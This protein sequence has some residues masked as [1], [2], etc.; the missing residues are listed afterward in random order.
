MKRLLTI[1][2]ILA[3]TS[4]V[5]AQVTIQKDSTTVKIPI[6]LVQDSDLKSPVTGV[7]ISAGDLKFIKNGGTETNAGGTWTESTNADGLYFYT[8]AAGET[9]TVGS[10]VLKYKKAGTALTFLAS[11]V[12]PDPLNVAAPGSPVAGSAY[13][14]LKALTDP[15]GTVVAATGT[16]IDLAST[17]SALN[18]FL[19]TTNPTAILLVE[20]TGA[21]QWR[22]CQNYVGSNR[23]CTVTTW[24]TNPDTSTKYVKTPAINTSSGGGSISDS[25]IANAVWGAT[26]STYTTS[27][28]FG[29]GVASVQGNVTGTVNALAT[30]AKSDV[31][32]EV[33]S[34]LT[35]YAPATQSN[36]NTQFSDIKGTSFNT[37]TDSLRNIRTGMNVNVTIA[38][39]AID[40]AKIT[41]AA[42]NKIADHM[43]RRNNAN[44]ES[45]SNGDSLSFRSGYGAVAKQTNSISQSAGVLTIYKNDGTT[46]LGTQNATGSPGATPITG[47]STN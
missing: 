26:R 40:A 11:T 39:S 8:P 4:S 30:Q 43:W 7:T 36:V 47:L 42:A 24:S 5:S 31:N 1:P 15:D 3:F 13:A 41:A 6:R 20:G 44:V 46:T 45:S 33:A 22:N 29:Q 10:F 17:E 35:S 2:L 27:G 32:A 14:R 21:G 23:R 28:T 37:S 38:D 25:Q 9:D 18:D 12:L 34:A 19:S 16:T